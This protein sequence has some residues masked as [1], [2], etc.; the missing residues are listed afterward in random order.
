MQ[1]PG[2]PS[3]LATYAGCVAAA[4]GDTAASHEAQDLKTSGQIDFPAHLKRPLDRRAI[5]CCVIL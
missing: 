5:W 4:I 1:P 2:L 3:D